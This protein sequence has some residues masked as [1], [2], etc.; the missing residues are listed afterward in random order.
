MP[1]ELD[2]KLTAT[3]VK[4]YI[5]NVFKGTGFFITPQGHILTAY[6]VIGDYAGND[7]EVVSKR[8][9]KFRATL[10]QLKNCRGSD[11]AVLK[12]NFDKNQLVLDCVPL[13]INLP[14]E[15]VKLL[16]V[17]YPKGT[18][19]PEM[20]TEAIF[21][22]H[23][24][25]CCNPQTFEVNNAIQGAG[26][27]GGL[28]YNL[29]THRVIGVA[30]A[31]HE[32]NIMKNMGLASRLDEL[33]TVWKELDEI[34][35]I[36][37]Q[38]WDQ[39]VLN[40]KENLS[41]NPN[42]QGLKVD[43]SRLPK[44]SAT[45]VGRVEEL[46]KLS[47]S[48]KDKH[49]NISYIC[50]AGGIGKSALTFQWLKNMQPE[51]CNV[52]KVFAWSFYSQGSHDTQNSSTAFF[53]E[54]LAFFGFNGEMPKDD[55]AKGR[56][57]VKY[58]NNQSFILILDGLEPLQHRVNILDGELK[59]VGIRALIDELFYHGLKVEN[60]LI[61]ISSRQPLK[62]LESWDKEKYLNLDL[63]TLNEQDSIQLL[64]NLGVKGTEQEFKQTFQEIQGYVLSLI[65]L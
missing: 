39:F 44:P 8:H 23:F 30:K 12:I 34:T 1:K 50:A 56:L 59:D 35:K 48:L 31:I 26:Q 2:N 32:G 27:S 54:A 46:E 40:L 62:E 9:G 52:E 51:Y 45:L 3:L 36:V 38:Q 57:L 17:G 19:H 6:H 28:I 15:R 4:I 41:P 64:Q 43:I 18:E 20:L 7:I 24:I 16:G 65:L 5:S 21:E 14:E 53:Q 22:G 42:P 25:R 55:T 37:A 61:L 11:L 10:E 47:M 13:S 29:E 33:F 60:S 63:K 58:L 49:K